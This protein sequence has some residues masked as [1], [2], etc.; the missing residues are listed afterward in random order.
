[1]PA[2][3]LTEAVRRLLVRASR[4]ALD[5]LMAPGGFWEDQLARLD[6]PE[7][8]GRRGSAIEAVLASPLFRTRLQRGLN[9]VAERGA[10]RAAPTIA[11]AVR[12][13]GIDNAKAIIAGGPSAATAF[14]RGAMAGMLIEAMAPELAETMR[15]ADD[16]LIGELLS[17]LAGVDV[18]AFSHS[19][20][21]RVDSAI[22]DAIGREE[23]A[24]R[25]DP[26]ATEDPVLIAA[27][28]V[29]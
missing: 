25:A 19:L 16:P 20:A 21:E 15:I 14:L 4:R 23:A 12:T 29:L 22:W 26:Q 8:L 24:I 27:L 18:R 17:A 13:V 3:S 11:D 5:R 9:R 2:F 1:M 28:K 7:S 6:L 10:R